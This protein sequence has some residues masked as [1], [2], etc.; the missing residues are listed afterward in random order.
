MSKIL[1]ATAVALMIAS[2]GAASAKVRHH[3]G[4]SPQPFGETQVA[5]LPSAEKQPISVQDPSRHNI[6]GLLCCG[7][8]AE[9]DRNHES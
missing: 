6:I 2:T 4:I 9:T 8:W 3:V 5:F 7:L 1:V